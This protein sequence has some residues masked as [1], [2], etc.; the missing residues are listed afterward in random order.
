MSRVGERRKRR[1]TGAATEGASVF[2]EPGV[3]PCMLRPTISQA[4]ITRDLCRG[5]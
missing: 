5:H 3:M 1:G 4:R 2:P